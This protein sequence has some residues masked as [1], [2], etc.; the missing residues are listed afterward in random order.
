MELPRRARV[1]PRQVYAFAQAPRMGWRGDPTGLIAHGVEYFLTRYRRPDGLFRAVVKPDG[2]SVDDT[3]VLYDQAF[4]LL[5]FAA[6]D[7]AVEADRLR[8]SILRHF[9]REAGGFVSD[10][11]SRL[12]LQSN[13]HMHLFEASL[14]WS[15]LTG[16]AEWR[17]LADE[18]GGLAVAR[19]LDPTTGVVRENYAEDWSPAPGLAGRVVEPGHQYEWAWLLLRW[20]GPGAP[21]VVRAARRLVAVSENSGVRHGVVVSALLDDFSIH[22]ATARL[23]PQGERLKANALAARFFGDERYWHATLEA[24]TLLLEFLDTPIRGLW[25]DKRLD[26]GEFVTEAVPASS[27]YHIVDAI[28]ELAELVRVIRQ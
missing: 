6:A 11:Q 7:L 1:Q 10:I 22:N 21:E 19:L 9:K 8:A 5:G 16:A 2:T 25:Y 13:P 24:A 23:W 4:A 17:G 15:E 26:S 14:A 27:F 18:I 20:A 28:G 12:P 3:P